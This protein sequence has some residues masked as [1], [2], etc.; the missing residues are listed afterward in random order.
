MGEA[1][2]EN[3]H[4]LI[5]SIGNI[6]FLHTVFILVFGSNPQTININ[7]SADPASNRALF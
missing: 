5:R 7:S 2:A 3:P 6:Y 1:E 4:R